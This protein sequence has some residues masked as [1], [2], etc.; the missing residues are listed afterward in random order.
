MNTEPIVVLEDSAFFKRGQIIEKY[1]RKDD[2]ILIEGKF[3]PKDKFVVL[4]EDL[5]LADEKRVREIIK[6]QFKNFFYNLYTRQA[7]FNN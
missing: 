6:Q 4:K 7:I 1:D 2:G 3:I 5:S